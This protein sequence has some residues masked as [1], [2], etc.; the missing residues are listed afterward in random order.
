MTITGDSPTFA[1]PR[2]SEFTF[3]EPLVGRSSPARFEIYKIWQIIL[4]AGVDPSYALAQFWAESLY[5]TAGWATITGSWGNILFPNTTITT[6]T[7]YSASNGYH[8]AKYSNWP[9]AVHDYVGLLAQYRNLTGGPAG[10]TSKIYWATAKWIGKQPGS[11]AH[12]EYL[13]VV[14]WR[15]NQYEA[16]TQ[17]KEGERMIFAGNSGITTKQRFL[18]RKGTAFSESPG[19]EPYSKYTGN[20][21]KVRWLGRVNN[22]SWGAIVVKT[23]HASQDGTQHDLVVYVN[24]VKDADIT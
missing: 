19:A 6:A 13:D 9:D 20:D 4:D 17:P 8:Y 10:D 18:L 5:G 11:P 7:E 12:Q 22:T 14:L 2:I 24:G 23:Q 16:S 15:M 1:Q 3:A 21:T